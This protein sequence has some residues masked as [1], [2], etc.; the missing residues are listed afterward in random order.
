[1]MQIINVSPGKVYAY[2]DDPRTQHRDY[3]ETGPMPPTSEF[4]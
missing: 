3:L 2:E 1:M 4:N